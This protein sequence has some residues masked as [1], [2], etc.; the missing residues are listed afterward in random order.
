MKNY[1]IATALATFATQAMATEYATITNVSPNYRQETIN[2][3]IQRCDIV[4]VPVYGN[5][6]GGG[7]SGTDVLGGMIIGGLLGK[8]I[9]GKD[10]G[11]AAGA[12]LGGIFQAD[13]KQNKQNQPNQD[14]YSY[15]NEQWIRDETQQLKKMPKYY[16]EV[17]DF[18]IVQDKVY[19]EVMKYT[20]TYIKEN[21]S[22]KKAKS[23]QAVANCI[24]KASKPKGLLHC[25]EILNE[26]NHFI[27]N[28]DMYGLLAYSNQDEIFSWQAPIVWSVMPDEK[29]VKKYISHLS[30]P[31][32]GIYD[33]FI[34]IDDSKDDQKTKKFKKEFREKYFEFIENT[35]K[36]VLP[37]DY[38]DFSAQDVWDV[39]LQLLD[40]MGCAKIKKEDP[41]YYNVL[42]KEELEKE[43]D[44]EIQ[45]WTDMKGQL[46]DLND[47]LKNSESFKVIEY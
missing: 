2:T 47:Q 38:K 17:D 45:K 42:T 21:P 25:A 36:T 46:K 20:D 30:P 1:I 39:E 31:Q 12:V 34:Y 23:I 28:E 40:A 9:T 15:V 29:N 13:K 32:L 19:R 41:N 3:P 7:A 27:E 16:V 44:A 43:I 10:N 26:V 22:S 18:R 14:F 37:N 33:Y 4:D 5:V 11:A 6:G 24:Q 8:G 35:F